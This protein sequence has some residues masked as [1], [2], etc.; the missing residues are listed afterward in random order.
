LLFF[1]NSRCLACDTEVAFD[2]ATAAFVCVPPTLRCAN[3]VVAACNWATDEPD[4]LCACCRLTRTRPWDGDEVGM[5]AFAR[6]Q[7]AGRRLLYQLDDLCLPVRGRDVDPK[8]GLA[9][10]LL[11]SVAGPVTTGHADGVITIDLAEGDDGHRE[12]LR[13]SLEEPYRTL[14]GHF[15]HEIGHYYWTVLVDSRPALEVFRVLFGDER[16]DYAAALAQNYA[17]EPNSSWGET[18]VSS[19]A[20]CH[21]WE[22]WAETFAH[23]LHIRDTLQTA[24]AYR[25]VVVGPEVDADPD[26][27]APLASVPVDR[28]R[29]FDAIIDAW[30]PLSYALN[31][32]N[33]SMGK[34]DAYPFVL[35]PTVLEKLR[36]VHALVAAEAAGQLVA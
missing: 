19:Y 9:F 33:R 32:M 36:L 11:S 14:L 22:D 6:A 10:D 2:R 20:A 30:L 27:T 4:S 23:Y 1:E 35:S 3:A 5:A 8:H 28:S 24:A 12:S 17:G 13:V 15:R 25:V 7:G 18:Y 29:D 31:A 34:D 26:P 16:V 21:P